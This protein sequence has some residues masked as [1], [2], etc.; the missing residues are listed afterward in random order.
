MIA[1]ITEAFSTV[2]IEVDAACA[3]PLIAVEEPLANITIP[4][5]ICNVDDAIP[6]AADMISPAVPPTA[7]PISLNPL[8][9]FPNVLYNSCHSFIPRFSGAV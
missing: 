5:I 3:V 2:C 4:S 1:K 8:S 9:T 7:S 6:P